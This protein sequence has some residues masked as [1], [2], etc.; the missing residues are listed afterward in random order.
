MKLIFTTLTVLFIINLCFSQTKRD[1][2]SRKVDFD[3]KEKRKSPEAKPNTRLGALSGYYFESFEGTFP[4]TG[5]K[6]ADPRNTQVNWVSSTLANLP[7]SYDGSKSTYMPYGLFENISESYLIS[8]AFTVADGDSLSFKFKLEFTGWIPDTTEV[9]ISITDDKVT[10]FTRRL[11]LLAEGL[12]YPKDSIHWYNYS[13]SLDEYLGRDIYVAFKNRNG[14]GD[15]VFID[16]VE[17]G[18]RPFDVSTSKIL[19][20]DYIG[21][22]SQNV[23]ATIANNSNVTQNITSKLIIDGQLVTTKM[24]I[25]AAAS[26]VELDFGDWD[27]T[28]GSRTLAVVSS[29]PGDVNSAN[30]TLR[31]VVKVYERLGDFGWSVQDPMPNY[32]YSGIVGSINENDDFQYYY[33]SGRDETSLPTSSNFSYNSK[34]ETWEESTEIATP[35]WFSAYETIKDNIYCFNGLLTNINVTSIN[36]KTQIYDMKNDT[37]T[38]GK[39]SPF[40]INGSAS[41]TYKDSLI[42]LIGGNDQNGA[43]TNRVFIYNINTDKWD[44]GTS[45]PGTPSRAIKGSIVGNKIVVSNGLG[46]NGR[47]SETYVGTIDVN[48]PTKISWKRVEDYPIKN[49]GLA[50]VYGI[51]NN[52]QNFVIYAGGENGTNIFETFVYDIDKNKWLLGSQRN[53]P[54]SSS[55]CT[56]IIK[57]DSL[58]LACL[59]GFI[60]DLN[61]ASYNEWLNLGKYQSTSSAEDI[62]TITNSTIVK[63]YPNPSQHFSNI[64]FML[65]KP[66]Q[67]KIVLADNFGRKIQDVVDEKH[68]MGTHIKPTNVKHLPSGSYQYIVTIDGKS[69]SHKMIKL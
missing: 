48:D 47:I 41:G 7:A 22:G 61:P 60:G 11:I 38:E 45:K 54:L 34:F 17:L 29:I 66:A 27:A 4:P 50:A 20:N 23:T 43:Y 68:E 8:P 36:H 3:S 25:V 44:N 15:G 10:S 18:N 14:D 33:I 67:V 49:L 40:R 42:Y 46:A 9:L 64:E 32:K 59:G 69:S 35:V 6:I 30:D 2:R 26:Q 51:S 53:L 58:Y 52:G 63:C 62:T 21:A 56:K 16:Y 39:P 65:S 37:W 24:Q 12:N 31:K 1:W 13:F 57:N 28:E 19:M 55:A 5:W